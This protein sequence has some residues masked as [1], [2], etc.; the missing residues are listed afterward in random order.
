MRSIL[1]SNSGYALVSV[2]M[3]F[4][5]FMILL[6][7]F[8]TQ[9]ISSMKQNTAVEKRS[10]S[11]EL[12][13]MGGQYFQYT[14]TN[15]SDAILQAVGD[16]VEAEWNVN[17]GYSDNY[18]TQIAITL[19]MN[20]I[21]LQSTTVPIKDMEN[22]HFEITDISITPNFTEEQIE[23]K[24]N[25]IGKINGEESKIQA[26][27]TIDFTNFITIVEREVE[28]IPLPTGDEIEEP[29]SN[30][31]CTPQREI[32]YSNLDCKINGNKTYN[33]SAPIFNN[34]IVKITGGIN[35]N[36]KM[37]ETTSSTLYVIGNSE[38]NKKSSFTNSNLYVEGYS[39]F[40]GR[41]D[42]TDDSIT[43]FGR[44]A[45]FNKS[46]NHVNSDMFA[47]EN[48]IFNDQT[49][50]N[51]GSKIYITGKAE[52][53]KKIDILNSYAYFGS[54]VLNDH[55]TIN[56][57][58][59]YVDAYTNFNKQLKL[60]D[61]TFFID[62]DANFN[63]KVELSSNAKLCINGYSHHNKKITTTSSSMIFA[64]DSNES[65]VNTTDFETECN[66]STSTT[67]KQFLLGDPP[68]ILP[69]FEYN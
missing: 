21:E 2:L 39:D 53:N 26:D 67:E 58:E 8:M 22:A 55:I 63:D 38:L 59:V 40:N 44:R 3:V 5:I 48:V 68:E 17:S 66:F 19:F 13:E 23:F 32:D 65:D 62:G 51:S 64:K 1:K 15:V 60:N 20:N 50:I 7:T 24:S 18:Y 12:A 4:T 41:V 25:S 42:F 28:G 47:D 45:I 27:L 54:A 46:L 29:N 31:I 57:S 61:S 9:S 10:Q 16:Q 36:S 11:I 30:T 34:S 49:S 14:V 43:Y 6:L 52:F 56:G 69:Y 35:V 33:N 37:E